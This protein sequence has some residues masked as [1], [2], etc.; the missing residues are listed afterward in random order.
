MV[1]HQVLSC[2][3][4]NVQGLKSWKWSLP[5]EFGEYIGLYPRSWTVYSF[6]DLKLALICKQVSPVIPGNYKD[7][8]LPCGV[9]QW[10]ALN[11]DTEHEVEVSITMTWRGPR[12]PKR[13]KPP[14]LGK[15]GAVCA[16]IG[17]LRN[18]QGD[19]F[20]FPF[21]DA[22]KKLS[23]CLLEAMIDDMPCCFGI[24]SKTT[25]KVRFT[26]VWRFFFTWLCI[27]PVCR[28]DFLKYIIITD[29]V[30]VKIMLSIFSICLSHHWYLA[31]WPWFHLC[32]RG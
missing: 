9:F 3:A 20:T 16:E 28:V 23:G 30:V 15:A 5:T 31:I 24:A 13:P 14:N 6:P 32:N 19:E 26:L 10:T 18:N 11:F 22:D 7:S 8:C 21:D 25:P 27:I 1:Y 4:P 17:H 2:S 29:L 12:A